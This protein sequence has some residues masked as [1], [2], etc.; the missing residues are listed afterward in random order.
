MRW[1]WLAH[2]WR[3][4]YPDQRLAWLARQAVAADALLPDLTR[5]SITCTRG[6]IRLTGR[7][8]HASDRVRIEADI[9]HVLATTGLPYR[10][11]VNALYVP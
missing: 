11:I 4:S 9:H 7:V 8:P 2:W 5:M 6:V 3:W 10:R 1:P